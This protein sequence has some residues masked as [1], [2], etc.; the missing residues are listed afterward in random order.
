MGSRC[1][2]KTSK[3]STAGTINKMPRDDDN[4][5]EFH[6]NEMWRFLLA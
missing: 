3:S 1:S 4:K 2:Q 5:V 6:S